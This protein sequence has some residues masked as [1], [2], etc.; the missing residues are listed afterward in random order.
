MDV[1]LNVVIVGTGDNLKKHAKAWSTIEGAAIVGIVDI[2]GDQKQN[3]LKDLETHY[4]TSLEDLQLEKADVIDVCVPAGKRVE[5]VRKAVTQ[6]CPIITD[7][8]VGQTPGET[9]CMMDM[10]RNKSIPSYYGSEFHF[11]PAFINAQTQIKNGAIG[12]DGAMRLAVQ[13]EHPGGKENIFTELGASLFTWVYDTFG[14]VDRVTTKHVQKTMA[15]GSPME[16]AVAMLRMGN[17][18]FV[19]V[20]LSWAGENERTSYEFTGDKGMLRYDSKE[21]EPILVENFVQ[22]SESSDT[23]MTL[24]KSLLERQM[25]Y[26]AS[27]IRFSEVPKV[28]E[29]Q[30]MVGMKIAEAASKSA[31]IGEPIAIQRS[32]SL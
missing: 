6:N 2:N 25:E 4:R 20:E 10:F 3:R 29:E 28:T 17:G 22:P 19:H 13:K 21:S 24:T 7:I 18:S 32:E 14:N 5:W 8:A 12:K 27:C 30:V 15:N 31:V 23:D 26:I 11:S 1:V 9:S 16:Y